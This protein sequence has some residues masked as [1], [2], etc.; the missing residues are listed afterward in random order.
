MKKLLLVLLLAVPAFAQNV[1]FD[2]AF[3]SITSQG[4]T[5]F[6]VANIPPLA[7]V[8]AVCHSP[9]NAVPCTNYATTYTGAGVACPNGAQD[10]P[11]PNALT[12]ACQSNGDTQ[13]NIGFWVPAGQYD[14]TVCIGFNCFGPYTVTPGPSLSSNNTFT[15]TNTFT[16]ATNLN[17]GGNIAGSWTGNPTFSGNPIFPGT[18]SF[19]GGPLFSGSS[20]TFNVAA[21]LNTGGN[22]SGTWTGNPNLTGNPLFTGLTS[23]CTLNGVFYVGGSCAAF[24]GNGDI[25]AQINAA[26]AACPSSGCYIKVIPGAYSFNTAIL[27]SVNA[28]PAVV[29]CSAGQQGITLPPVTGITSLTYLPTTGTAVT[30]NGGGVGSGMRGCV[31][32]GSS[33]G[34]STVGLALSNSSGGNA[35]QNLY[36]SNDISNFGTGLLF[37]QNTFINVFINNS[38]HDDGTLLSVPNT[39]S[40][41][42][43][44]T[45]FFGG[46]FYYKTTPFNTTCLN[47]LDNWDTNFYG[48]SFD[49]CGWTLNATGIRM[50]MHGG[51]IENPNGTGTTSQFIT[52]GSSCTQCFTDLFG[53]TIQE[54]GAG[55]GRT[56]F[57]SN[58]ANGSHLLIQGGQQIIGSEGTVTAMV[59]TVSGSTTTFTDIYPVGGTF[60]TLTSGAG[61][62]SAQT[63]SQFQ[64]NVSPIIFTNTT[65]GFGA[66]APGGSCVGNTGIYL[67]S[68]AASASTVLYVCQGGTWTAVTVP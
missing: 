31:L 23:A 62:F 1:R 45:S 43:E 65:I 22:I 55:T 8:L 41:A 40:Q 57:I 60:T 64:T 20:P 24:W 6:L 18:P 34:N 7:P 11:A 21:N 14:Y 56:S 61:A 42:Q 47:I 32:Q 52:I 59:A 48:V 63:G 39:S 46:D 13:G 2:T 19:T 33:S 67:N 25:G 68:T 37:G 26:Y 51:H 38:I 9:A 15:G 3:P 5:P 17:A 66:G 49:Q 53:V 44:N 4:T 10:T 58:G 27:F 50:Q 29:D 16:G 12:S 28:K 36:E 54:D 30:F 35:T